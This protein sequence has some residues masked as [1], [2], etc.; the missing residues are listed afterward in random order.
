MFSLNS[1]ESHCKKPWLILR[2]WII[3]FCANTRCSCS[4]YS[5]QSLW[6]FP[7]SSIGWDGP[8]L[9]LAGAVLWWHSRP[10]PWRR[11]PRGKRGRRG[12]VR[13][14][15]SPDWVIP[16]TSIAARG[17]GGSFKSEKIYESKEHVPIESFVTILIDWTFVLMTPTKW[18]SVEVMCSDEV[19][20]LV[21]RW[22]V[23]S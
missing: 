18:A 7:R 11:N 15:A 20:W 13:D 23:V 9:D 8:P 12:T 6:Q 4:T 21:L 22:P 16:P 19:M 3:F 1:S 17:G 14:W 10:A 2:W 5:I